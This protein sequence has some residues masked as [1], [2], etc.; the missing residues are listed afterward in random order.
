MVPELTSRVGVRCRGVGDLV[1]PLFPMGAVLFPDEPIPLCAFDD[2]QQR[3]VSDVMDAPGPGRIGVVAIRE[4]REA[5]KDGVRALHDVGC[6]A[7]VRKVAERGDGRVIVI[8]AGTQ[9]FRVDKLDRSG[10]YLRGE[11]E[12]L[13]EET[14]DEIA[15]Q[16][17]AAIVRQV[18]AAYLGEM[19]GPDGAPVDV[20]ALPADPVG[21]SYL[22][23]ALMM[24][25]LPVKQSLL[26]E[27]DALARLT[28]ERALLSWEIAFRRRC[29][30]T[31]MPEFMHSSHSHN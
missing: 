2:A 21:L 19:A 11:V 18:F 25:G 17:A 4:G 28:A 31:P 16:R 27:P 6:V 20:P 24:A 14:G 13:A 8:A 12:V 23:A 1:L 9:R 7:Q 26:A 5:G 29:L 22:V 15:A 3:L 10:P 30:S